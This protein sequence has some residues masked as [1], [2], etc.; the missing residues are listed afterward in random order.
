MS[1]LIRTL[2]DRITRAV[3]QL[4]P[5]ATVPAAAFL[6][7]QVP[8]FALAESPER[9]DV[10]AAI[11]FAVDISSS[12]GPQHADMQ[13][14][15]HV[16]ALRSAEVAAAIAGGSR[17]CIAVTYVEWSVPGW[18]RTVLP[19]TRIC[20][21][22][23]RLAAADAIGAHGDTGLERRGRGGTALSYALEASSILLN[24][25]PGH[26]DRKIIDVSANGTNNDDIP[27]SRTRE[28]V[29]A[30]GHVINAIV[31]ERTEPGI[32]DDLPGYFRNSVVGG[33]GSFVVVPDSPDDY[34]HALRRKLVLEIS[35]R[36]PI[37]SNQAVQLAWWT[38]FD[39]IAGR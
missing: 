23:A 32:T 17:G 2:A 35:D 13:R 39:V 4:G 7:L 14:I 38:S 34:A 5:G 28:R 19:W 24:R 16:T 11:V 31:L 21:E 26:A 15:G 9:M 36:Q 1:S 10:D 12:I 37:E 33:P 18:L 3:R 29:V 25:L 22:A 8:A 27:V 30:R 20:D 6:C